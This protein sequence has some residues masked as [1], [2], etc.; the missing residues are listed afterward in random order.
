MP[1]SC[2]LFET[3]SNWAECLDMIVKDIINCEVDVTHGSWWAF[4]RVVV[5]ILESE[6]LLWDV[7]KVF[8]ENANR[9]IFRRPAS[10]TQKWYICNQFSTKYTY[11]KKINNLFNY[12]YSILYYCYCI[13]IIY[14]QIKSMWSTVKKCC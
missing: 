1:A 10:I 14:N 12:S 6:S 11:M 5:L 3:G 7:D 8:S 2:S 4:V 9:F 13:Q